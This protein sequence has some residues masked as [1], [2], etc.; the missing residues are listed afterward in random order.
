MAAPRGSK[1]KP[2]DGWRKPPNVFTT[3]DAR[4]ALIPVSTRR[5]FV[6]QQAEF[7][8]EVNP[9]LFTRYFTSDGFIQ[10][11]SLSFYIKASFELNTPAHFKTFW[12]LPLGFSHVGFY[13]HLSTVS[14][15]IFSTP[16][17]VSMNNR[18]SRFERFHP[19]FEAPP[20]TILQDVTRHL[21]Q[22]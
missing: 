3:G 21:F 11:R 17:N 20:L 7:Q 12:T 5:T 14:R 4:L 18:M 16:A 22:P 8:L 19:H 15:S 6:K 10:L 2:L 9:N 1:T 13:F